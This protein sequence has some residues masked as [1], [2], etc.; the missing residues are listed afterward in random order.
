MARIIILIGLLLVLIGLFWPVLS[1]LF[2]KLGI[3]RL[4]GDISVEGE[5][6]KFYFPIMSC[7]IL[8]VVLSIIVWFIQ[9]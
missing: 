5:H 8:S 1:G 9:K 3:G 2:D 4:P 7:L 6:S